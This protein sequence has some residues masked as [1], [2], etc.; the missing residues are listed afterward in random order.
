MEKLCN[1][2]NVAE[3]LGISVS[4]VYKLSEKGEI[5]S[6]KIGSSLRFTE[7]QIADYIEKCK[8]SKTNGNRQ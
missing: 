3:N 7:K 2:D 4:N 8:R 5:E 1:V 6:I